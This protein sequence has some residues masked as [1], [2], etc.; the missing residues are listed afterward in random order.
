MGAPKVDSKA[1]PKAE[2]WAERK[3]MLLVAL[4]AS[5]MAGL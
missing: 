2:S 5:W 1:N 3:V 4:M